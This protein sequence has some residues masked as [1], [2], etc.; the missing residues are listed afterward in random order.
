MAMRIVANRPDPAI[1]GLP[2]H[3]P[4]EE[5]PDDVVVPLPRGLSRHIVRIVRLGDRVYAVKETQDDIAFREYRLLRDLQRIGMPAVVAAGRRHRPRGRRR[6]GAAGGPD[7]P[8]PA[9]LAALPQPLQPRHDRRARADADRRDRRAARP[10]APGRLLLG[11]R[12]AVQRAVPAQRRRVLGLPRRR[13]DRRA[14]RRG[15]RADA[16]V[17][18]HRRLR[19]H[20]RRAD[21]PRGQ[22]R[23]A[24]D[25]RLP[26]HRAPAHPLRGAVGRADRPGG[27]PRRRDVAHRAAR[28]AA[29]RARLRRRRA[30]HR[31]R[32]RRRHHPDPAQGRRPRPPRPRDPGADRHERRGEPGP[33]AAQR[34]RRLHRALRPRPRGPA[35]RGEQVDARASSSR[36]WR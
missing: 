5:W 29:Q 10:P 22:R 15:R 25:R 20:L 13:R 1:L 28:G 3:L 23:R 12:V 16:G 35:P 27:V 7:H 14:A 24:R 31:H 26:D 17:R 19:E 2:W 30:R 32:P 11:R 4:L 33:P 6:R 34:P 21:G 9:V 18:H 8:A 36:S